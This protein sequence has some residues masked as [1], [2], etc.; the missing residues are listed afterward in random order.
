MVRVRVRLNG[1]A[2]GVHL[3]IDPETMSREEFV[4]LATSKLGQVAQTPSAVKLYIEG[5]EAQVSEL[6]KGDV[7]YVALTGSP[8]REGKLA[9]TDEPVIELMELQGTPPGDAQLLQS[10]QQHVPVKSVPP[11]DSAPPFD[12]VLPMT[13]IP[14]LLMP[15]QTPPLVL[16]ASGNGAS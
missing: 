13:P 9:R 3:V 14:C 8:Y 4:E 2:A 16:A 10:V 5:D 15:F 6:E 7:V 1:A 11:V 12:S